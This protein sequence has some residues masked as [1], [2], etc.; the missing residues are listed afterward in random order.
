MREWLKKNRVSKHITQ[1]TMAKKCDITLQMYNYIE[2][3]KRRPSV[4]VAKK[5]SEVLNFDWTLFFEDENN[6]A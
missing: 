2:N 3:G 4:E 6:K 5:I 1:D